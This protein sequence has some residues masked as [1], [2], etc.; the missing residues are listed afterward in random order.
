MSNI[1]SAKVKFS[2]NLKGS[3][4][5]VNSSQSEQTESLN[6]CLNAINSCGLKAEQMTNISDNVLES[7]LEAESVEK[8]FVQ[9]SNIKG[10]ASNQDVSIQ[11]NGRSHVEV[12][13]QGAD[14]FTA[15]SNAK[16]VDTKLC[17]KLNFV[18]SDKYGFLSP[19]IK[20]LG[21]GISIECKILLPALTKVNA[22]K[23]LPR[24][25]EKLLF[26]IEC[27]DSDCGLYIISTNGNLGYTEKQIC[28]ITH[29]YINKI[30]KLEVE[31]CRQF[32]KQDADD[33]LDAYLRAKAILSHCI[34]IQQ[35]EVAKLLGNVLIAI[36]AEIET[37]VST[38][39][40]TNILYAI[41]YCK[42]NE[43]EIAKEIQKIL[44]NKK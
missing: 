1:I 24:A 39:Q 20:S 17:N 21:T 16:E 34:K 36:N 5:T 28:E 3:K 6:L 27:L 18:Y 26:S 32:A 30:I 19:D 43:K 13:S 29:A 10:Y 31:M 8:E 25:S 42:N 12:F 40:I 15:Y 11:I 33:V 38:K 44:N 23:T 22:I 4:F 35:T 14:I 2:R 37:D 7:M 9:N 41:K